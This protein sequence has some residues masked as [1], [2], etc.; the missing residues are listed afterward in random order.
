MEIFYDERNTLKEIMDISNNRLITF[1]I[2]D[3]SS[4]S[5]QKNGIEL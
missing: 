4:S 3:G 5:W 2:N 1:S